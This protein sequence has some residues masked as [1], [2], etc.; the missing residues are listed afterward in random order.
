MKAN[1]LVKVSDVLKMLD[2]MNADGKFENYEDYSALHDAVSR[3]EDEPNDEPLTIYEVSKMNGERVWIEYSV[4]DG[5]AYDALVGC[6]IGKD[7]APGH[8]W[9]YFYFEDDEGNPVYYGA[10]ELM[11]HSGAKV[12]RQKTAHWKS[13]DAMARAGG[14]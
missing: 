6:M 13:L 12:Y 3:L 2:D 10:Y 14:K 4:F 5:I 8:P 7:K 11:Y 9:I 1:E